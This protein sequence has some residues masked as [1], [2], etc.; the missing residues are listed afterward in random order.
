EA[1]CG[2]EANVVRDSIASNRGLVLWEHASLFSEVR[3]LLRS[4]MFLTR[5]LVALATS[6][7]L[8][9]KCFLATGL[10]V[11]LEAVLHTEHS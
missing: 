9:M 6:L 7:A 3:L 11:L 10:V 8:C 4:L 2:E 5:L 1:N